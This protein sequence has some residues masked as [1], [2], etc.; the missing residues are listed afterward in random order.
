MSGL[1]QSKTLSG[2]KSDARRS[3]TRTCMAAENAE[4]EWANKGGGS[5]LSS[6][7]SS[8]GSGPGDMLHLMSDHASSAMKAMNQLRNDKQV[9]YKYIDLL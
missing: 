3:L 5:G 8:P 2:F 6:G 9:R 4:P 7:A 1:S